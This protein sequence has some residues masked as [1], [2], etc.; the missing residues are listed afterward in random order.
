M[1]P[2]TDPTTTQTPQYGLDRT[3]GCFNFLP[4]SKGKEELTGLERDMRQKITDRLSLAGNYQ[5]QVSLVTDAMAS[6]AY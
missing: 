3:R 2:I 5:Y 1:R 6:I 4:A